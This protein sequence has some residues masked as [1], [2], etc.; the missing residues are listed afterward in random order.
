MRELSPQALGGAFV[1]DAHGWCTHF[2]RSPMGGT[3]TNVAFRP[4]TNRLVMTKSA[5]GTVLEAELPGVGAALFG[6]GMTA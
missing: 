1:I 2:I 4:G 5:S 6:E 3:V